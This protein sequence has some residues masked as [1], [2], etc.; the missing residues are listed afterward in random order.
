MK[1]ELILELCKQLKLA[2][3]SELIT[4]SNDEYKEYSYKL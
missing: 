1:I 2:H 3:V 4:S